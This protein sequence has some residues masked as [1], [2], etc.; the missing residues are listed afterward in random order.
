MIMRKIFLLQGGPTTGKT[1]L[2]AA[3]GS[4][5]QSLLLDTDDVFEGYFHQEG[6]TSNEGWDR[7]HKFPT[8]F[9]FFALGLLVD[10]ICLECVDKL[11]FVE[12]LLL[13]TNLDGTDISTRLR[14]VMGDDSQ[15]EPIVV[16]RANVD[17]VVSLNEYRGYSAFKKS[18]VAKW[19]ESYKA[20]PHA[21]PL[22]RGLFI[23]D[24]LRTTVDGSRLTNVSISLV[25]ERPFMSDDY[26]G[27]ALGSG[28]LRDFFGM[29]WL[30]CE[31][32]E[33][34]ESFFDYCVLVAKGQKV[35]SEEWCLEFF[36]V[37]G[38]IVKWGLPDDDLLDFVMKRFILSRLLTMMP[39]QAEIE[40]H[41]KTWAEKQA[42]RNRDVIEFHL[43]EEAKNLFF[44]F[45]KGFLSSGGYSSKPI[46]LP[47]RTE[48][49][50]SEADSPNSKTDAHGN[51]L[52]HLVGER[53]VQEVLSIAESL[54]TDFK[55]RTYPKKDGPDG[56]QKVYEGGI[57][58]TESIHQYHV[59]Y[60]EWDDRKQ[61]LYITMIDVSSRDD[62]GSG[63]VIRMSCIN[64]IHLLVNMT[65]QERDDIINRVS[66]M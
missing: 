6:M 33:F 13:T 61:K 35:S 7:W 48:G 32:F 40:A 2:K 41:Y 54:M 25:T 24:V 37:L 15:I 45:V 29:R 23:D 64:L 59:L 47:N 34:Q 11:K 36:D 20:M 44:E 46:S 17:D 58:L 3:M 66:F 43:L 63:Q 50:K 38:C 62:L 19:I 12:T 1:S 8:E 60:T 65:V 52:H 26:K 42:S 18:H 31:L 5:I 55:V 16:Y 21:V 49:K 39:E 22:P 53:K 9:K 14:Q 57:L 28:N 10:R 51:H 56:T 30:A 27:L 4:G